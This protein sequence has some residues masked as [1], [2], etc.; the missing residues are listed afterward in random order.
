MRTVQRR[1]T[2]N[3][4]KSDGMCRQSYSR[5]NQWTFTAER[6]LQT[7]MV[8]SLIPKRDRFY[9]YQTCSNLFIYNL[10]L[11]EGLDSV[12]RHQNYTFQMNVE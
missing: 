11:Y 5:R 8:F 7:F 12:D 9:I 4:Y 10:A 1:C 6:S 2:L 3:G